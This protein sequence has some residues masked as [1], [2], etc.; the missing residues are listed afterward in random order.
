MNDPVEKFCI[1]PE[2][3]I[4]RAMETIN[5]S[6]RGVMA[7]VVEDGL[8]LVSTLTDGDLR[9]AILDGFHLDTPVVDLINA[10]HAT[11]NPVIM[12][13]GSDRAVVLNEMRRRH[14]HQIPFVDDQGRVV[15]IVTMDELVPDQILPIQAVIMAGGRGTRL[16]PLTEAVPKP[17]LP[18]GGRPIMEHI[19]NHLRDAGI[20]RLNITT[21][22]KPEHIQ[23]HFSDGSRFGVSINY[24]NE[25]QPLGTAG[26]IGLID[27]PSEPLLVVNGD[28]LTNINFRG[29]LTF[30][31]EQNAMMTVAVREFDIQ[32]PYGVIDTNGARVTSCREKPVLRFFVNAGIYLLE[33]SAH[34]Q[35]PTEVRF[36]MTDL[37]N[38]LIASGCPVVSYPISEYWL[39]IGRPDDY[40]RAQAEGAEAISR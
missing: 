21:H 5:G 3:T 22:Y 30:H 40:E 9:R 18:V 13:A 31:K 35:I 15:E 6:A 19:V 10:G 38:R 17:M 4:R 32:V 28:I 1:R 37:I 29:M 7:L 39:D 11:R 27:E 20:R 33:P 25:E 8:R 16:Q 2:E 12:R 24:V 26:A 36:D 23:Q 34:A 14:V